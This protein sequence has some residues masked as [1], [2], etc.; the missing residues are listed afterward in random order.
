M[1]FDEPNQLVTCLYAHVPSTQERSFVG[2]FLAVTLLSLHF[3]EEFEVCMKICWQHLKIQIKFWSP[4][5]LLWNHLFKL[6]QIGLWVFFIS[7]GLYY[8]EFCLFSLWN[9]SVIVFNAD[10]MSRWFYYCSLCVLFDFLQLELQACPC[11]CS[12]PACGNSKVQSQ[13]VT[14][15]S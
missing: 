2:F 15:V 14:S 8:L 10:I 4:A 13:Y 3:P 5:L 11:V 6:K 12:V 1:I 7:V 9:T